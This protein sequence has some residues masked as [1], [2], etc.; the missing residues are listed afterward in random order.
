M[1]FLSPSCLHLLWLALIPLALYL[2]RRRATR[3]PVSTL[4]FFRALAREHQESAWLRRLKKWVSLAL[5]LWV[6]ILGV[7][8]LAKPAL[9]AAADAP[10][11]IVFMIDRSASM[12]AMDNKVS[13]LDEARRL[14]REYALSLADSVVVSLVAFDSTPEVMLSRSRNHR[15]LLRLLDT[16]VVS[17]CE[18]DSETAF[19]TARRLADLEEPSVIWHVG[20]EPVNH[21]EASKGYRF[22]NVA[23]Q[24]GT[25]VGITG[26]QLRKAPLARD[27]YEGFVR[28]SAAASNDVTVAATLEA[29]INGRLAQLRELELK[30]GE[31]VPLILPLEGSHGEILEFELKC[32]GD[33]MGWDNAVAAPLPDLKPLV[34]AWVADAPDPFTDLALASLVEAGHLD[35]LKGT[36]KEWPL[37]I[38]PDVYVFE[39]WLPD[40][41]PVDAPVLALIPPRSSGPIQATALPKAMPYDGVR[42]V[43]AEHPVLYRVNSSRLSLTQTSVIDKTRTLEALWMAG[44][45]PVLSAGEAN[46]QRI[47]VSAFSPSRSEQLALLPAY[48][49]LLGNALYWCAENS[50]ALLDLKSMRT[51]QLINAPGTTKWHTWNGKQFTM[52]EDTAPN[53][54]LELRRIGAYETSNG[55]AGACALASEKETNLPHRPALADVQKEPGGSLL[56]FG[57][58][59]MPK[60]LIICILGVLVLE[61]FLFH[62]KAVY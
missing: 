57:S 9:K 24:K 1:R 17:P 4:L 26:F 52:A 22:V 12:A 43:A 11:A 47:V 2:F 25:N 31:S 40:V 8:A 33:C 30:P 51:G 19:A 15:E 46:G 18:G 7:L 41:W 55:H 20:D 28:V 42:T 3:V 38:K 44:E 23:L 61:S 45:E 39:N 21:T 13:R 37:K 62:R 59:S 53:S 54:L 50:D 14:A 49:L 10:G 5:T 27:R 36:P 6:L 16:L 32:P 48:P 56:A 29:R 35:I 60:L 58:L 34:V